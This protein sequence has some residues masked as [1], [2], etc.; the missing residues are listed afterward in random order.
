M[1]TRGRPI[2]LD[3]LRSVGLGEQAVKAAL[4]AGLA[5]ALGSLVPGAPPQ[6]YLAP[7][8][9]MLT[10]QLTVAESIT[11]AVQRT[12]GATVGVFV[13]V[14]AGNSIGVNPITIAALVLV[15][16]VIGTVLKLSVI[17]TSQVMVTAL[18][19]LTIGGTNTS[20]NYGWARIAETI[21]GAAVGVGINALLVPPSYLTAAE[22]AKNRVVELLV[23]R[24][25][26][27]ASG[28]TDGIT[29]NR[30]ATSLDNARI[31]VRE[32]ESARQVLQ[33]AEDSLR[34]NVRARIERDA[35]ESIRRQ[36]II[37]ER[38]AIQTRTIARALTD[39]V[40][41]GGADWLM[42]SAFGQPIGQL[43]RAAVRLVEDFVASG[44]PSVAATEE[45]VSRR[46]AVLR[47]ARTEN[48]PVTP[49]A[50]I[51]VAAIL[52]TLDRFAA[53]LRHDSASTDDEEEEEKEED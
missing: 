33:R 13:A 22:S 37:L 46:E 4:A 40:V 49:D 15:G 50:R 42:P 27:I 16:Q 2:S 43:L 20:Y 53:D 44:G 48:A 29:I 24:L 8:T 25:E 32:F 35:L 19:V 21:V 45:F 28:L 3:R 5:W 1:S 7:L 10:V 26:E 52:A 36:V 51:H 31:L 14:L 39:A 30:A 41:A 18:L 12:I 11:G 34:F 23:E 9:A 17:G 47:L 6:P 38:S